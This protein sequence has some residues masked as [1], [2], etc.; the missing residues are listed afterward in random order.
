[1]RKCKLEKLK[2][3]FEWGAVAKLNSVGVMRCNEVLS[4]EHEV[5]A[6]N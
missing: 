5:K 1:M 2:K 4:N 3:S 6:K